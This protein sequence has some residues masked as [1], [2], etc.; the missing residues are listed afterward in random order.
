MPRKRREN[1]PES[2]TLRERAVRCLRLALGA[3]DPEF[4]IKLNV[5]ADEYEARALQA[6]GKAVSAK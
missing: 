3:G 6:E 4:A 5:I 2:K 1:I